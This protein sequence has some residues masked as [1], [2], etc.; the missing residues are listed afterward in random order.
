[1]TLE[2]LEAYVLE[3]ESRLDGIDAN[4]ETFNNELNALY[5]RVPY[6]DSKMAELNNL[7]ASQ[8][9]LM[10]GIE[11]RITTREV[12]AAE[13]EAKVTVLEESKLDAVK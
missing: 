3:L 9:I 7:A 10:Q 13:I 11:A 4:Q 2:Q 8:T 1:M 6:L 5:H 12:K